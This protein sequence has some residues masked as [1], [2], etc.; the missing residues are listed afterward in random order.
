[1]SISEKELKLLVNFMKDDLKEAM[2][3][4]D[5]E[6]KDKIIAKILEHLQQYLED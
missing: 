4:S 2:D 1:M 5:A 3:A 6:D